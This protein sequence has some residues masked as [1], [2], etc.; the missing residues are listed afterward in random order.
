VLYLCYIGHSSASNA[1]V[2]ETKVDKYTMRINEIISENNSALQ[3]VAEGTLTEVSSDREERSKAEKRISEIVGS[4]DSWDEHTIED[5]NELKKLVNITGRAA[6]IRAGGGWGDSIGTAGGLLDNMIHYYR[7]NQAKSGVMPKFTGSATNA[8][9]L[10]NQIAIQT[11]GQYHQRYARTWTTNLGRRY[12]DP[13]DFVEYRTQDDYDTAWE[14]IES[15]GRKVYYYDHFK[16]L[17]TAV[18]IGKFIVEQA[19][20][21]RN[22]FSDNPETTYAISVRTA[23][24][25]NKAVRAQADITDQQAAALKDIASTKTQN[26]LQ[27]IKMLMR[28]LKDQE[29]IKSAIANS[30]KLDSRDKAKLD[31]IIA[32][33][34]DFR[35]PEA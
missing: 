20:T 18:K 33:A 9:D 28:V 16:H 8:K 35:E 10:A 29:D 34:K 7:L 21:V 6:V 25:I 12:K 26:A 13:S 30:A 15:K 32:G 27:G 31:Q 4:R 2:G 3:D 1:A 23:A 22:A 19:T 5:I 11:N 24:V 14:W 17:N